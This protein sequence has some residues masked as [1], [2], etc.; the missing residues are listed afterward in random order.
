M[1]D[2]HFRASERRA[3]TQTLLKR[4]LS[5]AEARR[6]LK[7]ETR[8]MDA[9][10]LILFGQEEDRTFLSTFVKDRNR[11]R[12]MPNVVDTDELTPRRGPGD[13]R[14]IAVFVGAMTHRANVDAILHFDKAIWP[15]IRQRV[16]GAEFWIVGAR[17]PSEVMAI[18]GREGIRVFADVPDVRPYI[19]DASVYVAPLRIGSGVKVKIME[20]LAS[21]KA[22]V[23]TDVAAE[24]M[25]L[26][27]GID[28]HVAGSDDEFADIVVQLF[29]DMSARAALEVQARNVAVERFSFSA[30]RRDLDRVYQ[31]SGVCPRLHG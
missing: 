6:Y 13:G 23:A 3:A 7:L 19:W 1:Y 14:K 25:G 4:W 12:L 30:G 21:G 11:L 29:G 17:P 20:A 27:N 22:I 10:D 8:N 28:L 9:F 5:G 2:V 26:C 31:E 15:S 24:G 16:E 18:N